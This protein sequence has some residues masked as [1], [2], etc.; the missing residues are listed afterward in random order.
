MKIHFFRVIEAIVE[1]GSFSEAAAYLGCSQSNVSYAVNEVEKF[2][3]RHLFIR[4][5]NGCQ[6]TND[7]TD[8][9]R[10][11]RVVLDLLDSMCRNGISGRARIAYAATINGR[12]LGEALTS[13]L[14]R[15]PC[16]Q[17]T[18]THCVDCTGA[19]E[20][21]RSGSAD[22]ALV[23]DS[24]V[25]DHF[26]EHHRWADKYM[27]ISPK[28]TVGPPLTLHDIAERYE[29]IS[30]AHYNANALSAS[31]QRMGIA[32]KPRVELNNADA[33]TAL[34]ARK[35]GFSILPSA[36]IPSIADEIVRIPLPGAP[37]VGY[38]LV[39]PPVSQMP[40]AARAIVELLKIVLLQ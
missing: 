28:T 31:L 7:G 9:V 40:T 3:N 23:S 29:Y 35:Q 16:I 27:L 4:D 34:I 12:L 17:I 22:I 14:S 15:H 25:V 33:V 8:I 5:R 36:I 20:M 1:N 37:E 26:V 39:G 24:R 30:Y 13:V 11:L 10:Q 2:F 18:A 6:L 32:K 38:S 21:L 19:A